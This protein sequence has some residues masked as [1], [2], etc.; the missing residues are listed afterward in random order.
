MITRREFLVASAALA[1]PLRLAPAKLKP[2]RLA[3][4]TDLHYGLA[5]DAAVRMEAFVQAVKARKGLDAVLQMGDFCYSDEGAKG[6][7]DLWNRVSQPKLHVLGNHD[8]DKVDKDAAMKF[9]GMKSRYGSTKLGGYRFIHLDLNHFQ[10]EGKLYSYANGNY[11]TDNASYNWADPEQLE[12][13]KQELAKSTEPV[14]IL[15][16]QPLGF[17]E[18]EKPLP[19]E[20]SQIMDILEKGPVAACI[21]GHLHVDRL[22]TCRGIPCLCVNS[23]SYFWSGGMHPY[24]KPLFAFMEF[25]ADGI[26]RIE[27]VSGEFVHAP[28]AASDAVKGRSASISSRSVKCRNAIKE[29]T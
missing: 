12:W 10:K 19:P 2:A 4:I 8:M 25:G 6:C 18:P 9:I 23:A 20:Q 5:P 15:A 13:L 17:A 29:G 11:F 28:P 24:T 7:M 22:E 16:H 21:F 26:L 27:G 14:I 3:A 1:V